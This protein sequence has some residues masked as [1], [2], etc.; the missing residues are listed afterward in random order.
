MKV[1]LIGAS[2][3]AG[4]RILREL[5]GR[6]HNVLAL[7]RD[8]ARIPTLP[9]VCARSLDVNDR[10][11]LG[12]A[13]K[14]HDAVISAVKFTAADT[15]GLIDSV[16]LSGVSRYLVVGGAGS[17][18]IAPGLLEMDSPNFPAHVKPEAAAGA[19][20]LSQLRASALDWTYISPSRF[21][22]PGTRTGVFRLG[23]DHL[24]TG[25]D[26]RSAISFED[27]A[28]AIVDELERPRHS[29]RRFTVGY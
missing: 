12:S 29:R 14:D 3:N 9:G 26:G 11:A 8:A 10:V 28:M 20:F 23:S 6:S 4:S 13:L 2:G 16:A 17:L 25:V 15:Q 7:A 22:Q 1:A 24:L 21:F 27:F 5:A 19:R 18:E